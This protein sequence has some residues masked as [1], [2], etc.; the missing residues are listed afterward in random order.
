[1]RFVE[2]VVNG[3][4]TCSLAAALHP[5]IAKAYEAA[6]DRAADQIIAWLSQHTT[7]RVGPRGGQV[8]V[9]LE[10]LEAATGHYTSRAEDPH[11][12]LHLQIL[13]RVFTA[14]KWRG[15]YTVDVRDSL[16]AIN[17]MGHAAMA[18]DPNLNAAFAAHGYTRD[19]TGEVLQLAGY[20]G[21][22]S[23]RN[24]QI[25]RNVDR[26]EREWT[27]AHPGEQPG[28]MLR[29]A[30]DARAWTDGRPD[31]VTPRPGRTL[32]ERWRTEL[33]NLDYRDPQ[34]PVDLSPTP[35][36]TLHREEAVERVLIRLAATRSAWNAADVRGEAERLIAAVGVVT[37]AAVRI[38]LAEDLTSRAMDRCVP[39]L[40]RDGVPE[41][42]RAWTS[43][44]VLD[45]EAD[46]TAR[47]AAR[48][49]GAGGPDTD[50]T[51]AEDMT[52]LAA[53]AV[54]AERLDA[55]QRAAAA[56]LAGD[57]PL[58]V[59]EGAAGAGK[60][61]TL[62]TTRLLLDDR[63][64][65]MVVVTPTL[66]AAKVVQ[67]EVRTAAASAAWLAFQ[68]GWRWTDEGAWT[69]L[70]VGQTDPASGSVCTGPDDAAALRP[71]DLLLVDEAGMLDQ[72][73]ARALLTVADECQAR[74]ALLGDRHQLA[75]VGRGGVLD[76]AARHVD[77]ACHLTL[78]GVHRFTRTDDDGAPVPDIAYAD[79]T[80]AMRTGDDP[81]AVFDVLAAR[82]QIRLHPD[83]AALVEALAAL[84]AEHR[85]K[86]ERVAVVVDTRQ[87][88][89]EL[90]AA[91]RDGLVADGRLDDRTAVITG[92][93][94][95]IGAGDR[96]ATRR[97][98][99]DLGVANRDA[100]TVTAV[101]PHGE[102][103]VTPGDAN[104][105]RVAPSGPAPGGVTP[106]AV[107]ERVLPA[108]YVTSHVELAYASTA[109]GVQGDTVPAAHVVIG[110]HTGAGAAY[111]GMTR[112]RI[113]NTA[114]LV[115]S[116]LDHAREQWIAVFARDRADLG[117]GHAAEL[118]AAEAARY[119]R[120]RP[121]DEVL[122]EL[123]QAWTVEQRC[124][125]RL[126]LIE[127]RCDALRELA[128]L[129]PD[130]AAQFLILEAT[131]RRAANDA[132]DAT[133]RAEASGAV[134]TGDA[135]RVRDVLL[136]E[137]A[138]Q[139]GAAHTAAQTLRQG[140]G[141]LGLR[142]AA[143]VRARDQL[144]A[145][146]DSWRPHLPTLPTDPDRIAQVA[147]RFDD[148]SA[149]WAALDASARR[150]AERAHPE[151]RELRAVADAAQ[152]AHEH[153]RYALA[154]ARRGRDQRLTRF[155]SIASA[156]EPA[157]RLAELERDVA[158]DRRELT[159]IRA[160]IT[161]LM[162]EPS[163][164]AQSRDRLDREREAWRAGRQ[165]EQAARRA[166]TMPPTARTPAVRVPPPPPPSLG[167]R[168]SPGRGV[169]R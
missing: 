160:R 122:V 107:G 77:P 146:A 84:T 119:A 147:G 89:T 63:G 79:L 46:L 131:S 148:R 15:L 137:W 11:W 39:L 105:G 60:T 64:R 74:L 51:L 14:G 70:A 31:K 85:G 90:G 25:A 28:P 86:A 96:I 38:E 6:Q 10:V 135:D 128:T 92:A 114:H 144:T 23:A 166:G 136:A 47:L 121:L 125:D 59:V 104:P 106:G 18:C 143:V 108:D 162:A 93:G 45:V 103:V 155:G 72:D 19:A 151:Y 52:P 57:R 4:K 95:R 1:V 112:G 40:D 66:K 116:N 169:P 140:P 26:Y 87:Q 152:R 54:D 65:R 100:W 78:D 94:Q 41:H 129:G 113:A 161:R 117:P 165:A 9:P 16:A 154:E 50:R 13:S 123:R 127:P 88:A 145:W 29:R 101:G 37:E 141:R 48:A 163:L 130:P 83:E 75:A 36:G 153:A 35:I 55:G 81:G 133:R 82:G 168:P 109:H 132:E 27:A 32:H 12:H 30:W 156:P 20:V 44:P 102:L 138:A 69:R 139:W 126:L 150:Q 167:L 124:L 142:R 68:H 73:T 61:T 118:A 21:P 24:A 8:Q 67:A 159:D 120:P 34:H 134:V 99:R 42:V 33:D 58:V 2:V 43:R 91:I 158:A 164:L 115:A 80:L 98:D 97:N 110:E 49:T 149:L 157:G 76:L 71:G 53:R 56:A 3:P 7:T 111:V 5:D 22:F 62:A 17:G